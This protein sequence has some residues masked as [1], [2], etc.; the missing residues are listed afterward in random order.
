MTDNNGFYRF[1]LPV[2]SYDM[3]VT[4]YAYNPGSASGVMVI[5]AQTTTQNFTLVPVP[6]HRVSGTVSNSVTGRPI[7]GATVR[8]LNTPLPPATTDADGNY[9]FPMVPDGTNDIQATAPGFRGSTQSVTVDHDLVVN[10]ALQSASIV[11]IQDQSPW[12]STQNESILNA[13]RVSFVIVDSTHMGDIDLSQFSKVIL[14]SQQPDPY[15]MRLEANRG[16]LKTTLTE[17]GFWKCIWPTSADRRSREQRSR[18]TST[19]LRSFVATRS[20]SWIL[21]ILW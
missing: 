18:S 10:F 8:V 3:T 20:V 1:R 16:R 12:G 7:Q 21:P 9:A 11:L 4:V 2:G 13:R 5:D 19:S 14:V 17:V 15:Y 6:S